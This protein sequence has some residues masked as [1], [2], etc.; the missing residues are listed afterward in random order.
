MKAIFYK[1]ITGGFLDGLIIFVASFL[2]ALFIWVYT[3]AFALDAIQVFL[4]GESK[5]LPVTTT[6]Y[7]K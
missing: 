4:N 6:Y 5:W 7:Y 1:D 2:V 3:D